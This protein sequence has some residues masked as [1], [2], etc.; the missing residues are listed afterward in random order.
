[1]CF[2]TKIKKLGKFFKDCL[3]ATIALFIPPNLGL[4]E[5][6]LGGG[7]YFKLAK[8][9]SKNLTLTTNFKN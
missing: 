7:E 2:A 9:C 3:R 6:L 4:A 5:T 8:I 1:M